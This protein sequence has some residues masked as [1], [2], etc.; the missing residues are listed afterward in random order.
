VITLGWLCPPAANP[1]GEPTD[2]RYRVRVS[3]SVL[4]RR[5]IAGT[6]AVHF[7]FAARF[8]RKDFR[9]GLKFRV[10]SGLDQIDAKA[11]MRPPHVFRPG[12]LLGS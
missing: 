3:F 2:D 1:E 10:A 8:A 4:S 11:K 6:T 7:F 9:I 12:E 5:G